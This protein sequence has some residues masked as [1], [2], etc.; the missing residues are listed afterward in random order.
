[1]KN[2]IV[3]LA[4]P[5]ILLVSCKKKDP[6]PPTKTEIL[7]QGKWKLTGA[8]AAGGIYDLMTSLKECQK[9]N[10]FTFNGNKSI[11]IDE[12]A[13]KC[14]DTSK[15]FTTDGNWSLFNN[16]TKMSISGDKITSGFGNLTGDVLRIDA[17]TFQIKKDTVVS[18][19]LTSAIVT[20]TNIK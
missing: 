8:S 12:G 9:D 20:F 5:F 2:I 16:D 11:T 19:F 14:S 13:S 4:S 7:T 3:L 10:F 1:M 15:Q 17:T 6:P 18:G